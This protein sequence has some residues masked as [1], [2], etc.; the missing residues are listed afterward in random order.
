MLATFYNYDSEFNKLNKT[1]ENGLELN[2]TLKD[3]TEVINPILLIKSNN[4][5]N[6]NYCYIDKLERYYF[7]D[8]KEIV[9]ND[10]IK[11]HLSV[12]VLMSY[13]QDILNANANIR[14]TDNTDVSNDYTGNNNFIIT[15]YPLE[16]PFTTDTDI[17]TT[18]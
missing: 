10:L 9:T 4:N 1:L 17:L 15:K 3:I 7:I 5:F 2:I 13:K 8:K 11:L 12:D 14:E 18:I 16:N 6:Y